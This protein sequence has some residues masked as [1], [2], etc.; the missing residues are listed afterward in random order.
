MVV[1]WYWQVFPL[2]L[3]LFGPLFTLVGGGSPV[4]MTAIYA[5]ASDVSTDSTRANHFFLI[6][7]AAMF[8]ESIAP[9]IAS[10]TMKTSPWI[11]CFCATIALFIGGFCLVFLPETLHLHPVNGT[12]TPIDLESESA[13]IASIEQPSKINNENF[14]A[15]SLSFARGQKEK[16]YAATEVLHSSSVVA[17]IFTLLPV[18]ITGI[19]IELSTR[20]ISKRYS[21]TLANAGFLLSLRSAIH[22]ALLVAVLPGIS[23]L[24]TKKPTANSLLRRFELGLT[25]H[26]KDLFLA[27][28]SF[29]LLIGGLVFFAL[30]PTIGVAIAA[31][32]ILT[33]GM[34]YSQLC[35]SLITNMVDQ[36]H[37]GRLYSIIAV[38]QT[39]GAVAGSPTL[40][41]L[42][43][44]GIKRARQTHSSVWEGLPFLATATLVL[45]CSSGLWYIRSDMKK[46][47][48]GIY[49]PD[50]DHLDG[51]D[52]A[53]DEVH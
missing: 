44:A 48:K 19:A 38:L 26:A 36:K 32:V 8:P 5:L 11:A 40:A 23:Y 3:V 52:E 24:L 12:T 53:F 1:A 18:T 22:L 39:L 43:S 14:W 9:S 20:Y 50:V 34:G 30:A 4:L 2:K 25:D 7:C 16:F 47:K 6:G 46:S 31:V 15:R 21:W 33:L 35:R 37:V 13:S 17:L 28:V 45:I 27:R 42:F 10:L 49:V 29:I 41:V 51:S